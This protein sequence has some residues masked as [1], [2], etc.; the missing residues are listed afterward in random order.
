VMVR[1][2]MMFS[3]L[4]LADMA[5]ILQKSFPGGA[6]GREDLKF[7]RPQR[8]AA[9]PRK[10]VLVLSATSSATQA[11]RFSPRPAVSR[12]GTGGCDR[13]LLRRLPTVSCLERCR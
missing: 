4:K 2:Y 10:L 12:C 11:P 7:F 6:V 8:K 9:P 5:A 3:P 13:S 1:L